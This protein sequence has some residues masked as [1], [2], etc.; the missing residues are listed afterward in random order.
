G[1]EGQWSGDVLSASSLEGGDVSWSDVRGSAQ[2]RGPLMGDGAR[3]SIGIDARRE[4]M[5][6]SRAWLDSEGAQQLIASDAGL[7]VYLR[8][9]AP[10]TTALAGFARIDWP[11]SDRHGLELA[12]HAASLPSHN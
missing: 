4:Q 5:P 1:V 9:V 10:T 3:F 12:L 6:V 7:S 8:S 11:F 2:L